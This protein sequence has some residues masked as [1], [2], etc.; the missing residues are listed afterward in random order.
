MKEIW[1]YILVVRTKLRN[2][3]F[4]NSLL[5]AIIMYGS[6]VSYYEPNYPFTYL[7]LPVLILNVFKLTAFY[8]FYWLSIYLL[9]LFLEAFF[10]RGSE[11]IYRKIKEFYYKEGNRIEDDRLIY[12]SMKDDEK[13]FEVNSWTFLLTLEMIHLLIFKKPFLYFF[14]Y[15]VSW[16]VFGLFTS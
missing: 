14:I 13:Y 15:V 8:F 7:S 4:V 2:V 5:F 6:Y 9:R 3:S 16:F 11:T 1:K 12:F 10:H